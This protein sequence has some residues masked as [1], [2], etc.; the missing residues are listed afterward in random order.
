MDHRLNMNTKSGPQEPDTRLFSLLRT[1]R[2]QRSTDCTSLL[3]DNTNCIKNIS[4]TQ[5]MAQSKINHRCPDMVLRENKEIMGHCDHRQGLMNTEIAGI[6]S[7]LC[8][9]SAVTLPRQCPPKAAHSQ[10]ALMQALFCCRW[11]RPGWSSQ[12]LQQQRQ[13]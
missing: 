9:Y 4:I 1:Q 7:L 10:P 12:T 11:S 13:V 6:H 5:R 3:P 8:H 2:S